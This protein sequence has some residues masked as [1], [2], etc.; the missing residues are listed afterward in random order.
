MNG[1]SGQYCRVASQQVQRAVGIDGEV[2]DRIARRPI[3]RGLRRGM[4]DDRDVAA[5]GREHLLHGRFVA[6]VGVDVPVAGQGRFERVAR[7]ARAGVVA[8]EALAHVVV[9][10]DDRQ[11][12][13]GEKAAPPPRRS[14]PPI[15]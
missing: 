14:S 12:L 6:N 2:G 13:A 8:E 7:P 15:L 4:N 9:D 3:V 11:A 10:A 5:V 1:A